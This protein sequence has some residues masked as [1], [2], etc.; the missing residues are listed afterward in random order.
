MTTRERAVALA[1]DLTGDVPESPN[2]QR[3]AAEI[4]PRID[5]MPD[6]DLKRVLIAEAVALV[7]A[8]AATA[9]AVADREAAA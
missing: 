3:F 9:R 8:A 2:V 7:R 4:E 6:A 1:A 5:T